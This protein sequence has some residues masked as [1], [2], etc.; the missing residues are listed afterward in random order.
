MCTPCDNRRM[1]LSREESAVIQVGEPYEMRGLARLSDDRLKKLTKWFGWISV[2]AC[3]V[4]I[5]LLFMLLGIPTPLMKFVAVIAGLMT[6]GAMSGLIFTQVAIL[7]REQ[8]WRPIIV[9]VVISGVVRHATL[10]TIEGI[11][12]ESD[13]SYWV[14]MVDDPGV[15]RGIGDLDEVICTGAQVVGEITLYDHQIRN[16]TIAP[17][18]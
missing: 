14:W 11:A 10:T 16:L 5:T 1:N 8:A 4:M 15:Y 3:L 17:K 7:Q 13:E 6:A 2:V 18:N 12:L 9:P